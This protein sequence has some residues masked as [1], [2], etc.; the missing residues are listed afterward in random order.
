MIE[1]I[2]KR[3]H[4]ITPPDRLSEILHHNQKKGIKTIVFCNKPSTVYFILHSLSN[5]PQPDPLQS[6]HPQPDPL[7]PHQPEHPQ[8]YSENPKN[9]QS[10]RI[11]SNHPKLPPLTITSI[12]SRIPVP[13]RRGRHEGWVLEG[14]S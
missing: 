14:N 8:T 13:L 10:N 3:K 11:N 6:D 2:V 4:F 12:H 5:H 1:I 7:Q 9:L